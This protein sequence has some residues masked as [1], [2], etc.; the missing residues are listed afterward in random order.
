MKR[1]MIA[2]A[3]MAA[4][5]AVGGAAMADPGDRWKERWEIRAECDREL[6]EAGGRRE[7]YKELRECNK[8]LAKFRSEQRKEALESWRDR[9]KEWRERQRDYSERYYGRDDDRDYGDD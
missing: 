3:A 9:D 2:A 8:E 7:F 5:F 6:A 4:P 1:I